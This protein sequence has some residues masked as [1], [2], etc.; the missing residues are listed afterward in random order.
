MAFDIV[1]GPQQNFEKF[2]LGCRWLMRLKEEQIHHAR[3]T[4]AERR[5]ALEHEIAETGLHLNEGETK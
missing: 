3:T 4:L 2:R 1:T 5:L